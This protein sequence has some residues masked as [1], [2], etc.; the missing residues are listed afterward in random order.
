MTPEGEQWK[1]H[2]CCSMPLLPGYLGRRREARLAAGA[3]RKEVSRVD[4]VEV[5]RFEHKL[6]Q[7][8]GNGSTGASTE[9]RK[10][11]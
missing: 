7:G 1:C 6:P 5:A 8:C 11:S 10:A 9:I 3:A 2:T 4:L